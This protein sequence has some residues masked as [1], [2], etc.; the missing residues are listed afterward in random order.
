MNLNIFKGFAAVAMLCLIGSVLATP[1]TI[2]GD[3]I[4]SHKDISVQKAANN[5]KILDNKI[6]IINNFENNGKIEY[7]ISKD[8]STMTIK[9]LNVNG[10]NIYTLKTVKLKDG[11]HVSIYKNG[12]LIHTK[13]TK[14]NP[15]EYIT[16]QKLLGGNKYMPNIRTGITPRCNIILELPEPVV[17]IGAEDY[18]KVDT[19]ARYNSNDP[20]VFI[21]YYV[22]LPPGVKYIEDGN[23]TAV[24][25][26]SSG[27]SINLPMGTGV[28]EHIL[29][30]C[31][32]LYWSDLDILGDG[33]SD[34]K[35]LIIKYISTGNKEIKGKIGLQPVGIPWNYMWNS[36]VIHVKVIN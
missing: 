23:P 14:N 4:G 15:I 29:G 32:I 17:N 25:K 2:S 30:P 20:L 10:N 31:T 33:L 34:T 18:L 6:E 16:Y 22:I 19:N 11:Y 5:V 28:H 36:D 1:V 21:K 8:Y 26:L 24:Y 12:V 7:I 27:Q 9:E 35:H 13:I 3:N